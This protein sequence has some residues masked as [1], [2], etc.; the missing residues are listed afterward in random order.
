[1]LYLGTALVELNR[2]E[3]KNT[4]LSA[5]I[6]SIYKKAFPASKRI[7]NARVQMEQKLNELKGGG[8]TAGS[9]FL[10][11]LTDSATII[12]GQQDIQIQ[13]IDFR[14]NLMNIGL[15]A[16]KLQSVETL[17]KQLNTSSTIKAEIISATSEKNR[18][19]GSIRMQRSGA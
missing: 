17:N 2:L 8:S 16:N 19:N 15:S 13:S 11:L 7:I 12:S 1:M 5:E 14:N 10:P 4:A 9:Q 18:V 6:D 3:R